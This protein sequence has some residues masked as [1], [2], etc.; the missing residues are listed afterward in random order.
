MW[1]RNNRGCIIGSP[2]NIL[3]KKPNFCCI[4]NIKLI[5]KCYAFYFLAGK[6]D[7]DIVFENIK[8]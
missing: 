8:K 2:P 5:F 6:I 3:T 7:K 1:R 4:S